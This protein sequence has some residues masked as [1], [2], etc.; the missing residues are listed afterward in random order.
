MY[1]TDSGIYKENSSDFLFGE[2]ITLTEKLKTVRKPSG[3]Y[4][5][6]QSKHSWSR[7]ACTVV[8]P[9]CAILSYWWE[10]RNDEQRK[11][12]RD[13]A[14]E[15]H[16]Y[17][18]SAW[19]Y[20]YVWIDCARNFWNEKNPDRE[21]VSF[22]AER[23][24]DDYWLWLASGFQ[25]VIWYRGNS[26][27]NRD[28]HDNTILDETAHGD[29]TYWHIRREEIHTDRY[30][31]AVDN[32]PWRVVNGKE[33]NDYYVPRE[34]MDDLSRWSETGYYPS[35]YF[36]LPVK[37]ITNLPLQ[38]LKYYMVKLKLNSHIWNMVDMNENYSPEERKVIQYKT[39][40]ENNRWRLHYWLK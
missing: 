14:V 30:V 18:S 23:N 7:N 25:A 33:R 35:A 9:T 22:R 28:A 39:A 26:Q 21:M 15:N 34:N 3:K 19:H 36:L 31:K 17:K 32:Y 5:W 27:W 1:Y 38:D 40:E 11:E 4:S 6:N 12:L 2:A 10:E 29:D 24:S 8:A 37:E 13:Y 16:W 20:M